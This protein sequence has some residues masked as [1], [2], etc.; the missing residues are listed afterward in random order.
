MKKIIIFLMASTIVL[1]CETTGIAKVKI[2]NNN[3]LQAKNKATQQA[4]LNLAKKLNT[5]TVSA[6]VVAVA[7]S[8]DQ[9]EIIVKVKCTK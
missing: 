6:K 1:G 2:T 5:D 9:K 8:E 4:R 3:L 7:V